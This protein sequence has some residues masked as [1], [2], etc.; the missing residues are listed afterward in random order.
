MTSK[1]KYYIFSFSPVSGGADVTPA[2][3]RARDLGVSP[4][5]AELR[6]HVPRAQG[7][8]RPLRISTLFQV[9]LNTQLP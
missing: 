5:T 1:R 8:R 3:G 9:C 7:A 2:A 6:G 4:A